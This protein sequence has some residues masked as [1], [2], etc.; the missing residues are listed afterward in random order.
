MKQE[1]SI[2]RK[3]Y[4]WLLDKNTTLTQICV[5][6]LVFIYTYYFFQAVM[7]PETTPTDVIR[8]LIPVI[9]FIVLLLIIE[10]IKNLSLIRKSRNRVKKIISSDALGA[11]FKTTQLF[12]EFDNISDYILIAPIVDSLMW[13]KWAKELEKTIES[14]MKENNLSFKDFSY[15]DDYRKGEQL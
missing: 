12:Y 6:I 13:R 5:A 15:P 7:Q 1:N 14:F 4:E 10:I 3:I 2:L 9:I 8:Y 11:H